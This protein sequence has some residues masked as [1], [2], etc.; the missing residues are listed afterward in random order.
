MYKSLMVALVVV[1]PLALAACSGDDEAATASK[2]VA[3][4]PAAGGPS[5][6]LSADKTHAVQPNDEITL[7]I[8]VEHFDLRGDAIGGAN[9]AGVGHYRIYLD[10]ASG[11]DYLATGAEAT[12]KVSIP[13]NITDGSHDLRVTL[14]NNDETLLDPPVEASVLL[15]V[16]RL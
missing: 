7:T 13:D 4:E 12:A 10:D 15:I 16:Y 3:N 14:V 5:V 9:E 2:T 11:D 1:V 6:T 8:S